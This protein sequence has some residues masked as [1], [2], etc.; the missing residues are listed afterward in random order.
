[1]AQG[2]QEQALVFFARMLEKDRA[3]TSALEGFGQIYLSQGAYK[4]AVPYYMELVRA[5]PQIDYYHALA[6]CYARQNEAGK[7]IIIIGQAAS[8]FGEP[9]IQPWLM[10]PA[11]DGIRETAEFRAFADRVVGVETRKAI[12]KIRQREIERAEPAIPGGVEPAEKP[13]LQ[14]QQLKPTR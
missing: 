8:L 9:A 7:T 14:L 2:D 10:E 1:M 12:E 6:V 4:S 13:S 3:N 11:L 5:N